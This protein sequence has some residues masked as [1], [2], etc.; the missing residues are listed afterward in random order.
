M[1][2]IEV[3]M[4]QDHQEPAPSGLVEDL[5]Q[6]KE[7][8]QEIN[9]EKKQEKQEEQ[10]GAEEEGFK[11]INRA[12]EIPLVSGLTNSVYATT[13]YISGTSA[14]NLVSEKIKNVGE[15]EDVKNVLTSVTTLYE[16]NMSDRVQ[17]LRVSL[18][19]TLKNLDE[20]ACTGIDMVNE[21]VTGT[22]EAYVDP[23]VEKINETKET[24]VDPMVEKIN[25]TKETYVDPMVEKINE[26]KETYV[27]PMV[28]KVI[29][30]KEQTTKVVSEYTESAVN[31]KSTYVDPAIEKVSTVKSTYV[32]PAIERVSTVKS[33]YVDPAVTKAY[34][35]IEDP[36]KVYGEAVNY[37]KDVIVTT[38]DVTINKAINTVD[39]AK[40]YLLKAKDTSIDQM[41]MYVDSS[42][43]SVRLASRRS[44]DQT[45]SYVNN[46]RDGYLKRTAELMIAAQTAAYEKLHARYPNVADLIDRGINSLTTTTQILFQAT[47]TTVTVTIDSTRNVANKVENGVTWTK[48]SYSATKEAIIDTKGKVVEYGTDFTKSNEENIKYL[49]DLVGFTSYLGA[50]VILYLS[51]LTMY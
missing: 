2:Q 33:T 20:Y 47:K 51:L 42:L 13:E 49:A 32:D 8:I 27:D 6:L 34:A 40:E 18:N 26:T 39:T 12:M 16:N 45:M 30:M 23:V 29:N 15:R 25:E 3:E 28:E 48:E 21:K 38:K 22:K 36:K 41:Q 43:E 14:A 11:C 46:I 5:D 4:S 44:L 10:E 17:D 1:V 31:A 35:A 7:Q 24:Y 50:F 19:P 37:G 9:K